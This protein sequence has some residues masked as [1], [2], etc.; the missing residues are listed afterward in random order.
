MCGFNPKTRTP[1]VCCSEIQTYPNPFIQIGEQQPLPPNNNNDDIE[2]FDW[3]PKDCGQINHGTRI[4][5]GS[6]STLMEF[7][8]MALLLRKDSKFQEKKK[9]QKRNFFMILDNALNFYCAGNLINE[10]YVLTAAHCVD[11]K[12]NL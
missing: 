1:E 5:G 4:T 3:L 10:R 7:P 2:N 9:M 6:I 12:F 8:W 11:N